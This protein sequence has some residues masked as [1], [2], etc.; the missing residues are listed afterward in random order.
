M[1]DAIELILNKNDYTFSVSGCLG[2]NFRD[3]ESLN[4]SNRNEVS[5]VSDGAFFKELCIPACPGFDLFIYETENYYYISNLISFFSQFDLAVD[6]GIKEVFCYK[7]YCPPG[8]TL[9]VGLSRLL[10]GSRYALNDSMLSREKV[11]YSKEHGANGDLVAAAKKLFNKVDFKAERVGIFFS[12]GVDSFSLAKMLHDKGVPFTLYVAREYP[13]YKENLT[14]VLRSRQIAEHMGWDLVEVT[15]E[16]QSLDSVLLKRYA[17]KM[18]ICSH[19]CVIFDNVAS[20][21]KSDNV[22]LA[23]CGQN[24]D[25][26]Y[27]YGLT[28]KVSLSYR[29][30]LSFFRR[31]YLNPVFLDNYYSGFSKRLLVLLPA[32]I[33]LV[34]FSILRRSMQWRIPRTIDELISCF[35]ASSENVIF[36]SKLSTSSIESTPLEG[37]P[38]SIVRKSVLENRVE[39]YLASGASLAIFSACRFNNIRPWLVYS[40]EYLLPEYFAITETAVDIIRP[41]Q[42][43]YNY[44]FGSDQ[45]LY[46]EWT[47]LGKYEENL[48]NYHEWVEKCFLHTKF[49]SIFYKDFQRTKLDGVTGAITISQSLSRHWIN[50]VLKL[51][52][53]A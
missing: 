47:R 5:I 4:F 46:S 42:Q 21:M 39:S 14:D 50:L 44:C 12:G 51:S 32:Y 17:E 7:S 29:G 15:V 9:F 22:T 13:E 8:M 24:L 49:G 16:Y 41:K 28:E 34:G 23:L 25:N 11:D 3:I 40:D 52:K 19:L 48:P 30:A 35:C 43:L 45:D 27:S 1:K 31:F 37:N 20:R 6:K 2:S 36:R 10:P 53:D 18:P 26:L 33:G 38:S